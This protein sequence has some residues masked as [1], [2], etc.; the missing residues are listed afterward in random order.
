MTAFQL[1][2]TRVS[3]DHGHDSITA[4]LEVV[5]AFRDSRSKFGAETRA[6]EYGGLP[7]GLESILILEAGRHLVVVAKAQRLC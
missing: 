1:R 3:D 5:D 6:T 2:G 4:L 7:E